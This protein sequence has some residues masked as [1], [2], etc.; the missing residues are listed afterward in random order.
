MKILFVCLGNICRSPLAKVIMADKVKRLHLSIEV[1][2]CGF[3]SFHRGD[4]ADPRS[5]AV[6]AA[7]GLDL[8][9]HT[10]RL[11]TSRDFDRFNRIYVMDSNNYRDVMD[12]A[13]NS[14]DKAKVDYLLNVITPGENRPVPDP[15]FAGKESFEKVYRLL[16]EACDALA[17][18]IAREHHHLITQRP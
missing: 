7:H 16:D 2:S 6:A 8:S 4:P 1:D 13:R 11:F 5:V 17:Q 9:G 12:A 18:Q 10:A 3:E 14:A 15:W